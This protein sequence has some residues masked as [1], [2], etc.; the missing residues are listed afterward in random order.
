MRR[1]IDGKG[2]EFAMRL[3][4]VRA[5]ADISYMW[6]M[7]RSRHTAQDIEDLMNEGIPGTIANAHNSSMTLKT[8]GFLPAG[9]AGLNLVD[10]VGVEGKKVGMMS[11]EHSALVA[12]VQGIGLRNAGARPSTP[13]V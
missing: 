7:T 5:M 13:E 6:A 12:L 8:R 9:D 10:I 1:E 3:R 4:Q 2:A 11:N